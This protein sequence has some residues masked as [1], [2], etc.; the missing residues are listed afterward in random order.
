MT[1]DVQ[2]VLNCLF[3]LGRSA[4]L[5]V[6]AAGGA[7]VALRIVTCLRVL[8]VYMFASLHFLHVYIFTFLHTH[9]H[10]ITLF[11]C[12]RI[13]CICHNVAL[14]IF[15]LII[16]HN[17]AGFEGAAA[18]GARCGWCR[19]KIG[20]V[21]LSSW[22]QQIIVGTIIVIIIII[23]IIITTTIHDAHDGSGQQTRERCRCSECSC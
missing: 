7:A 4:K 15:A 20:F 8:H 9:V 22:F 5:Q 1:C 19:W 6:K 21:K 2:V 18:A 23:I 11:H 17:F 14:C 10:V 12:A 16:C 13:I 3:S